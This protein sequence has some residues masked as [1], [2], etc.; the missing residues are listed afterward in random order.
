M[1]KSDAAEHAVEI[2]GNLE[3]WRKPLQ[4]L[5]NARRR[6]WRWIGITIGSVVLDITLTVL[7]AFGLFHL[8]ALQ[9][10]TATN[11]SVAHQTCLSGND[12]RDSERH[13]WDFV[14]GALEQSPGATPQAI[15]GE[16]HYQAVIDKSL[17]DRNCSVTAPAAGAQA[18]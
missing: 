4:E 13:T 17:A 8:S 16:K 12:A 11:A 14:F 7:V 6:Q 2:A 3:P 9:H 15:Q 10:Q 1:P 5:D 18:K